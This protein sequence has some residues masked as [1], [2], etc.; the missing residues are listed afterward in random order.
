[1]RRSM[2]YYALLFGGAL[3]LTIVGLIALVIGLTL[4]APGL[5]RFLTDGGGSSGVTVVTLLLP[6]MLTAQAFWKTEGRA[7][8]R[9]EGW[10]LATI[11]AAISVA[12]SGAA[13]VL[14]AR[15]AASAG[16]GGQIL[17]MLADAPGIVAVV[18][19]L[20]FLVVLLVN[21]LFF[22]ST[23]RGEIKRAE[24]AARR[25]ER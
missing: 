2:G 25:A 11:C 20:A 3:I 10:G 7:M 12:L 24:R 19:G 4:T 15:V 9:G 1:M 17:D 6:A 8:T 16:Q 23:I 13:F 22:W 14:G 18:L 21:K 5:A